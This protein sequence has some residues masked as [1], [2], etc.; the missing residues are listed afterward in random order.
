MLIQ[1]VMELQEM[2]ELLPEVV[3]VVVILEKPTRY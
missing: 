2:V 3:K 1:E